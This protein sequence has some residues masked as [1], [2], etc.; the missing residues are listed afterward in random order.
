MLFLPFSALDKIF[1][2]DHAVKQAQEVFKPR[3]DRGRDDPDWPRRRD[4]LHARRRHWYRRSRLRLRHCRLLCGDG[5]C[6]YKQFWA[7]GDFWSDPDGKGR[8]L[9]WDFLKNLSLGAGFLL[10][11]IGTDGSGL[12]A[13][14]AHP[15]RLQPSLR[16]SPMSDEP[17]RP[18]PSPPFPTGTSMSMRDGVSHQAQC[19]LTDYE[20]KGVGPADPQWNDKMERSEA[21]SS[22]PS[23]RSAGWVTGT[24]TRRRNGS[25][26]CRAV[27]G[28]R[29]W[30]AR[31]SSRDPGNSR[32]AR[33]RAAPRR[34]ARRATGP[35]RSAMSPAA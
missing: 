3:A 21:R 6:S 18:D 33:I 5:R 22:S 29:A 20:L 34:M 32:S 25:S 35:A 19:A 14:P 9:L 23:S 1:G 2:F 8:A 17:T 24:R 26:C 28:S 30:T 4:R 15:L 13:V 12:A 27:G 16:S 10:I 11:V 7:Q 31:G